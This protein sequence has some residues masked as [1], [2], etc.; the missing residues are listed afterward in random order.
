MALQSSGIIWLSNI[1]DEF[2]PG[3]PVT[4]LNAYYR[5]NGAITGNPE[6]FGIPM[7]GSPIYMSQFYGAT[8]AVAGSWDQGTPGDY[9]ITIPTHAWLRFRVWGAG[10]GGSVPYLNGASG[11][12]SV[13]YGHLAGGG[14]TTFWAGS[15]TPGTANGGNQENIGGTPANGWDGGGGPYGNGAGVGSTI[16]G[17]NGT[18][19]GGGG[20]G[21]GAWGGTSG[22][23][24][25]TF[26]GPDYAVTL[27]VHVGAGG[28][29]ATNG[30]RSGGWG[31]NGRVLIE[32]GV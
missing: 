32:W 2:R 23:F 18:W 12:Q 22:G 19:P 31:A 3:Q 28:A 27:D 20:G 6:N 9:R 16:Q 8:R 24:A 17:G 30:G 1:R 10:S 25:H 21:G 4:D 15:G 13:I 29:P 7:A 14:G 11:D 26:Y 5:N